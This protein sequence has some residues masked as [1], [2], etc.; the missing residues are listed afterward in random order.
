MP[1]SDPLNYQ[2]KRSG[3]G[4]RTARRIGEYRQL[5]IDCDG[6]L[7][8]SNTIKAANILEAANGVCDSAT[9][10]QFVQYFV[11]NNGVPREAK[12]RH[13]FQDEFT[14]GQVL[15]RYNRLNA[16]TIPHLQPIPSARTF[17]E[18]VA[19]TGIPLYLVSGGE[20]R[21]VR[22]LLKNCDLADSFAQIAGGPGTKE[23]HLRRL[24]LMGRTCFFGD[25][26]HDYD[27]AQAFGFD[28]VFLHSYTQFD[29]WAS[30][31][32]DR[33]DVLTIPDFSAIQHWLPCSE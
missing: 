27:V 15:D 31:F 3:R 14:A 29:E 2:T 12:I 1:V 20:E 16:T 19:H 21:E 30:Y 17:V 5:V 8:D 28:F 7:F 11:D 32:S 26:L 22:A 33:P 24:A 4:P 9:A 18:A 6:V 13:F 23:E 10:D 25:S